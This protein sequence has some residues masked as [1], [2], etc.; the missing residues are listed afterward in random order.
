MKNL[1]YCYLNIYIFVIFNFCSSSGVSLFVSF[2]ATKILYLSVIIRNILYLRRFI[3]ENENF[4]F[5]MIVLNYLFVKIF[6]KF[7]KMIKISSLRI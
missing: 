2:I 7:L 3:S 4:N 6:L 5:S 1:K